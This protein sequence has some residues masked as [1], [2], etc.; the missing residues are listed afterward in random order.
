[1]QLPAMVSYSR[2]SISEFMQHGT[3][4]INLER[5]FQEGP[6]DIQKEKDFQ[7]CV[8]LLLCACC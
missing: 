2:V 7:L 5:I 8:G 6:R 3:I 1:M 4:F